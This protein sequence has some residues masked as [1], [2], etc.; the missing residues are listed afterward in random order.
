MLYSLFVKEHYASVKATQ[1]I[2]KHGDVMS[3]L[4]IKYRDEKEQHQQNTMLVGADIS[5]EDI[6]DTDEEDD[7]EIEELSISSP[8]LT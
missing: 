4:S 5:G 7:L 6:I 1:N 2:Q 3:A 8:Q